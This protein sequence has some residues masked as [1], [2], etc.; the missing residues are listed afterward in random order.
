M[1]LLVGGACYSQVHEQQRAGHQQEAAQAGVEVDDHQQNPQPG[2]R[3]QMVQPVALHPVL[4]LHHG[5]PLRVHP[6]VLVG[7]PSIDEAR[8]L[9]GVLIGRQVVD[10]V[11]VGQRRRDRNLVGGDRGV[12]AD[13]GQ[14]RGGAGCCQSCV[15][16]DGQSRQNFEPTQNGGASERTLTTAC[17]TGGRRRAAATA[18]AGGCTGRTLGRWAGSPG[19]PQTCRRT[20]KSVC[21]CSPIRDALF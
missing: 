18:A 16:E 4:V 12:G 8:V 14:R 10:G 6:H 19:G 13:G 9:H 21:C 7:L 2:C 1:F 17:S 15:A 3:V 5:A 11:L 20:E